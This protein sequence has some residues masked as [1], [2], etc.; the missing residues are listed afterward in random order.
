MIRLF[1]E[2]ILRLVFLL[3][4]LSLP[5]CSAAAAPVRPAAPA[6]DYSSLELGPAFQ[7]NADEHVFVD[8]ARERLA[9]SWDGVTIGYDLD[10]GGP[11]SAKEPQR[12]S[13][14]AERRFGRKARPPA[15]LARAGEDVPIEG[16]AGSAWRKTLPNGRSISIS[17]LYANNY[18]IKVGPKDS[19]VYRSFGDALLAG[20]LCGRPIALMPRPLKRKLKPLVAYFLMDALSSGRLDDYAGW[21]EYSRV[22]KAFMS[23]KEIEAYLYIYGYRSAERISNGPAAI[24]MGPYKGWVFAWNAATLLFHKKDSINFTDVSS[25]QRDG[26]VT[27][28]L[29]GSQPIQGGAENR[30]GF[31]TKPLG[32]IDVRTAGSVKKF[33]WSWRQGDR[34]YAA[35]IN[36]TPVM[37]DGETPPSAFPGHTRRGLVALDAT[38]APNDVR[39]LVAA[40]TSYFRSLGFRFTRRMAVAVAPAF[41]E[42]EIAKG[43]LDFLVRD[44]HSDGDDD[45]AMVLY[46]TGFD[47]EGR[48]V[49]KGRT[50]RIDILFNLKKKPHL[51]RLPYSNFAMLLERRSREA[52]NPLVYLDGS[53]W[54]V[55]KAKLAIAHVPASQ[56]M[57]IAASSP[58]NFFRNTGRN[59]MRAVL[60]GVMQ[61]ASFAGLSA[62]LYKLAGYASGREDRFVLPDDPL[63]PRSEPLA[64][65]DRRLQMRRGRAPF[66]PYTPDGYI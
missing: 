16:L 32:E 23:R 43:K 19:E 37:N 38:L 66:K 3:C 6:C 10:R 33:H 61:G 55:E 45:D 47:L 44:G 27:F 54:G 63:Y 24:T 18:V 50:M 28:K 53:C 40:Y 48:K 41:V 56:L 59:A 12:F 5:E 26:K 20:S 15:S 57:E 29:L 21:V 1:P 64:R 25:Y 46:R 14:E 8:Q 17:R 34:D 13:R 2:M 22:F 31:Y 11:T 42:N 49:E 30:F 39:D 65:I 9:V 58:V 4:A 7:L 35:D 36:V 51:W 62:R 60:D 52:K